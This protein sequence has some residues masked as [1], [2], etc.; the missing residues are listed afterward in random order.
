MRTH[1]IHHSRKGHH[2][3]ARWGSIFLLDLILHGFHAESIIGGQKIV[4][5][6]GHRLLRRDG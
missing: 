5:Q 6:R 1:L 4:F 3:T 2:S